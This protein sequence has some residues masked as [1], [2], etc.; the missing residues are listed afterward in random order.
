[1][2]RNIIFVMR[3]GET[4]IDQKKNNVIKLITQKKIKIDAMIQG[5]MKK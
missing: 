2:R 5:L 4:Y 1:M 3:I